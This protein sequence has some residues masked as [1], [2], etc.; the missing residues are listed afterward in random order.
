MPSSKPYFSDEGM[1]EKTFAQKLASPF[2]ALYYNTLFMFRLL[3]ILAFIITFLAVIAFALLELNFNINKG[4]YDKLLEDEKKWFSSVE[5]T[6]IMIDNKSCQTLPLTIDILNQQSQAATYNNFA[7]NLYWVPTKQVKKELEELKAF[8][9]SLE[10]I[11]KRNDIEKLWIFTRGYADKSNAQE[12]SY[13]LNREYFYD[14]VTYYP[15]QNEVFDITGSTETRTIENA[16]YHNRDLIYL[17]ANFVKEV[18]FKALLE[19]LAFK[20][21]DLA[22]LEGQVLNRRDSSF[23]KVN[24]Y[25]SFCKKSEN[26]TLLDK[27]HYWKMKVLLGFKL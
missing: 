22:V 2:L 27:L 3:G 14:E 23:R 12:R 11:L 7:S 15:I 17:R 24:V 10:S 5:S 21:Y 1:K 19:K 6:N 25:I 18:Y 4:F 26:L 8:R 9:E 13:A 16:K 20:N